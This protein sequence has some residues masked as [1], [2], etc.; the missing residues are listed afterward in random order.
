[1]ALHPQFEMV[2]E[3]YMAWARKKG[4]RVNVWTV[5]EEQDIRRMIELG[6]DGIITDRPDLVR[7]IME[8][9]NL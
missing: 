5:N 9:Q 2:D 7:Q 4:Y 6:V 3:E 8:E 1:E